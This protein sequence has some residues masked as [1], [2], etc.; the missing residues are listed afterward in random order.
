VVQPVFTPGVAGCRTDNQRMYRIALFAARD[1]APMDEL[2]FDYGADY[3][4]HIDGMQGGGGGA[5]GGGGGDWGG[6]GGGGMVRE[7]SARGRGRG[8]GDPGGAGADPGRGR[9]KAGNVDKD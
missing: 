4:Q 8:R 3:W 6:G 7:A 9:G 1:I 5:G 2:C